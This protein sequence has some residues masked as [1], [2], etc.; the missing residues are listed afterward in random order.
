VFVFLRRR[1]NL[2]VIKNSTTVYFE[3]IEQVFCAVVLPESTYFCTTVQTCVY[4]L[5]TYCVHL[6]LSISVSSVV[7]TVNECCAETLL[8]FYTEL[9]RFKGTKQL[10]TVQFSGTTLFY[11]EYELNN[12]AK[13]TAFEKDFS[14][15]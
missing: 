4:E 10:L 13:A 8:T 1:K 14:K 9:T 11:Y 2:F 12:E 15:Q 3:S 7:I 6:F 5:Y